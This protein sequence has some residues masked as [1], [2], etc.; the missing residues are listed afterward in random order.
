MS[1]TTTPIANRLGVNRGWTNPLSP[2]A[3]YLADSLQLTYLKSYLL[4]KEYLRFQQINLLNFDIKS[5]A[6]HKK[7]LYLNLY[8]HILYESEYPDIKSKLDN[9]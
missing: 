2:Q 4:I 8:Q 5:I 9:L 3:I 7:T 1:Y 6:P